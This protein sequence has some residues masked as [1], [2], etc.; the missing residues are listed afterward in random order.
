MTEQR[1]DAHRGSAGL[2]QTW[3]GVIAC[4]R[5]RARYM[6]LYSRV[7]T[8]GMRPLV[9]ET[10]PKVA[11]PVPTDASLPSFRR[12]PPTMEAVSRGG[13]ALGSLSRPSPTA[14]TPPSMG[15]GLS[16]SAPVPETV[17]LPAAGGGS[18]AV[19]A[20]D[21]RVGGGG[22]IGDEHGE[23]FRWMGGSSTELRKLATQILTS[24][25]R[26]A[27]VSRRYSVE[28]TKEL[29][30]RGKVGGWEWWCK[31]DNVRL[32]RAQARRI[33]QVYCVVSCVYEVYMS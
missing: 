7:L 23:D 22:S 31:G 17:P 16:A 28:L 33:R 1:R 10:T 30:V 4:A 25:G 29:Q 18:A 15:R 9:S 19:G 27:V 11:V 13:A 12:E 24:N 3:Q 32:V 21:G 26:G 5:L 20:R 14:S 8:V 2:R 6:S